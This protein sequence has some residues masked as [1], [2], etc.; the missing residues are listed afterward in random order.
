MTGG[1]RPQERL[2]FRVDLVPGESP[3]GYLCRVA[4][5]HNLIGP[6]SIA[7]IAGLSPC[8]LEREN[9]VRQLSHVL[10]LDPE[11][12]WT[13]CYRHIRGDDRFNQ[14]LFY[15]QRIG[16]DDLN[17]GRPRLC[18]LCLNVRPIWWAVWDLG[19]V[20]ACPFHHCL[21]LNQCRRCKRKF[22]WQRLAVHQCRCGIDFRDLPVDPADADLLAINTVIHRA[23]G[24]LPSEMA[25][26]DFTAWALPKEIFGLPL[27][28]LLRLV[29]FLGSIKDDD[30]LRKKQSHF[31]AR[32]LAESIEIDR[33]AA[34]MLLD[35][36]RALREVLRRM[37]PPES[38]DPATLNFSEVFGNYYR[39]LFRVLPRNECGF[40]HD[41]FERFVMEDWKGLVRRQ[42]RY[43]TAAVKSNSYWISVTEAKS[44]AGISRER[45][46]NLAREGQIEAILLSGERLPN[47]WIRRESLNRWIAEH[48]LARDL[49]P[50]ERTAPNNIRCRGT[51]KIRKTFVRGF[52][53]TECGGRKPA[54]R[55]CADPSQRRYDARY[56]PRS[57]AQRTLGLKNITVMAVAQA[58]LIRFT[59]GPNAIL[60]TGYHF[61]REDVISIKD[62]FESHAV[63][64]IEYS[65]PDTVIALQHA[66]KNY[67]GRD[68]GLP[69]VIRA[70][71]VGDLA[72]VGRTNRF[73]GIT[74]YLFPSNLLRRYRPLTPGVIVPQEGF[75]NYREAAALL[76]VKKDAIR[77]LADRGFLTSAGFR[78]GF[79][80]LIPAEEIRQFAERYVATAVLAKQLHL[81]S[82]SLSRY[83]RESG[84][85]LLAIPMPVCRGGYAFFL[86]KDVAAQMQLPSR[87]FLNQ[88][89]QRRSQVER[90]RRWAEYRLAKGPLPVD[91]CA[92][93]SHDRVKSGI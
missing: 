79:A 75:L 67:L 46:L 9:G 82:L 48:D 90:K 28:P 25:E 50:P 10:R 41:A 36:P 68:V 66:V 64:E 3:R 5:E 47:C 57:E 12:W 53:D 32:N 54:A 92:D 56:M 21:L 87:E 44:I 70:V 11:E 17:Y 45:I 84:I 61:L 30:M 85:P 51:P 43:F 38:T 62:T 93:N 2:L 29:I 49:S 20:T 35:W 60:P 91:P 7:Q 13:I 81:N 4:Q 8:D 71:L 18:P 63:P 78:N 40:L 19:L 39:H 76:G 1:I 52:T 83:L 14:R 59:K 23:A 6:L 16:A 72:P 65:K 15:G 88:H 77:A 22:A 31:G 69:A 24:F 26:R 34:K 80:R 33:A 86:S 58:G 37:L 73:P 27:G 55:P 42:H 74:G 89:A